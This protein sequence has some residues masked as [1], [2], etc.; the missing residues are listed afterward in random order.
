MNI[1]SISSGIA[2]QSLVAQSSLETTETLAQTKLEAARGDQQAIQK[3][4]RIEAQQAQQAGDA[5][6]DHDGSTTSAADATGASLDS[7]A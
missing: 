5:D 1:A 4:A 3:L 2:K 6:G 7:K